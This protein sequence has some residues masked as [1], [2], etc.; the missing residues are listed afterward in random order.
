M[1]LMKTLREMLVPKLPERPP[2]IAEAQKKL[3]RTFTEFDNAT[4]A[5]FGV[6]RNKLDTVPEVEGLDEEPSFLAQKAR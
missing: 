6:P 4:A 3:S 5:E 2:E 1:K